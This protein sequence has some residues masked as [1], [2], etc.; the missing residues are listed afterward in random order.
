MPSQPA[1]SPLASSAEAAGPSQRLRDGDEIWRATIEN[2]KSTSSS[3][4]APAAAEPPPDEDLRQWNRVDLEAKRF[5]GSNSK[6][7]LWGDVVRRVTLDLDKGNVVSDEVITPELRVHHAHR[8][9]PTGVRN[10]ETTLIYKKV[11]D[12]PDPGKPLLTVPEDKPVEPLPQPDLPQED[13]RVIDVGLKRSLGGDPPDNRI[14]SRTKLFGVWR[15]DDVTE[16][17]DKRRFPVIAGSR[18]VRQFSKLEKTDLYY[19]LL[20]PET[21]L[22]Y[23]TKQSG[24]ELDERR[25]PAVE[26][27][28]F[29]QAKTLEIGNLVGSNA[30]EVITDPVELARIRKDFPHRIMPSR[31]IITKKAGELGEDWKAKARWILL[32]HKDPDALTTGAF[33]TNSFHQNGDALF[34]G[35]ASMKF[36]LYIMDVSSAFGQSDPH[37][38]E[39]GPL[40]ASIYASDRN[41]WSCT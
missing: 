14:A 9:L 38:R 28:M 7:P 12:H 11:P 17:G 23:L 37:E 30:I 33:C 19:G 41:S 21:S 15:A 6:G 29:D 26:R 40:F 22:S 27:A 16:W 32:G 31:F 2:A 1:T 4:A 25:I 24:K 3:S 34:A 13:A 20:E 36:H 10:V 39:Q 35:H 5:R 18:D 8:K